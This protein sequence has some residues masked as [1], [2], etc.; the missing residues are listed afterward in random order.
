MSGV[1][2]VH[3]ICFIV[4]LKVAF[5]VVRETVYA[6]DARPISYKYSEHKMKPNENQIKKIGSVSQS[7]HCSLP[8]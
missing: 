7:L 3:S 8:D 5:F 1:I 6:W 4:W 2:Y